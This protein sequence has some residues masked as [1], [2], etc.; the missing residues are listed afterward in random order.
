MASDVMSGL[1]ASAQSRGAR[2][3]AI[4]GTAAESIANTMGRYNNLNVGVANEFALKQTDILNEANMKNQAFTK[5]YVDEFNT[6]NQNYDNSKR[7]LR[8]NLRQSYVNAITYRA[9][10]QVL[11]Q[12]YPNYRI[13]PSTGGF[14][15][16][17]SGPP[18]IP[19]ENAGQSSAMVSNANAFYNW[20]KEDHPDLSED[21]ATS[22]WSANTRM[23]PQTQMTAAQN[24]YN[25]YQ[26]AIPGPPMGQDMPYN[27]YSLD[28]Y[29]KGGMLP[30][31]YTVGYMR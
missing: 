29:K 10:A 20:W 13:D 28:G 3:A 23:K 7:A 18:I 17:T 21:S 11:N 30:F 24:Y 4:Q 15:N 16:F 1:G 9:Q 22:I 2:L 19:D 5:Q 8:N 6:L 31:S 12:L 26:N 14:M 27:N 25:A